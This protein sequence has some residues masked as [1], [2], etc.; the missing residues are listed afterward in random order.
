MPVKG[1]KF[2]EV[3]NKD[4]AAKDFAEHKKTKTHET[5]S[6]TARTSRAGDLRSDQ[7]SWRP[8][9]TKC[10]LRLVDQLC[11]R[12]LIRTPTAV[13]DHP[14]NRPSRR[15]KPG[16]PLNLWL[17]ILL[18]GVIISWLLISYIINRI[19]ISIEYSRIIFRII[20]LEMILLQKGIE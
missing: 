15:Q 20:S 1:K 18:L 4:I 17:D 11:R 8:P 2:C 3:C 14:V 6:Q 10:P 19:F 7:R 9:D 5:K 12:L 16:M 13:G